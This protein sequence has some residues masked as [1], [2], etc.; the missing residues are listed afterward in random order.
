VSNDKSRHEDF[1]D[2]LS[3]INEKGERNWIYPKK[4][5]GKFY[6]ARNYVSFFLLLILFITPFIKIKGHPIILFNFL[7]RNFILFVIPFGPHDFHYLFLQ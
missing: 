4:P 5:S 6:T 2:S 1:R 3:T 7:N